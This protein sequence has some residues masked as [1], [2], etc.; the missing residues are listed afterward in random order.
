MIV[1]KPGFPRTAAIM[2][3]GAAVALL[4]AVQATDAQAKDVGIASAVTNVVRLKNPGEPQPHAAKVRETIALA[5]QVSTAA[6]S[7]LQILLLDKSTFSVGANARLTIDRFVYDP[8]QKNNFTATVA[9]GAFRF[10][11]GSKGHGAS[12][13][14]KTPVASI[15]VRGT[16]V[17]GIVGADAITLTT[18]ERGVGRIANA[19]PETATLVVLRGPGAGTLGNVTPGAISVE[20]GGKTV[21]T[22]RPSM[23]VFVPYPGAQPIGPFALSTSGLRQIED[24]ILPAADPILISGELPTYKRPENRRLPGGIV[25]TVPIGD[26]GADDQP[27]RNPTFPGPSIFNNLPQPRGGNPPAPVNRPGAAVAQDAGPPAAQARPPA[28]DPAPAQPPK[29]QADAPPAQSPKDQAVAPPA[30][31]PVAAV[32]AQSPPPPPLKRPG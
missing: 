10:M 23:A 12:S 2:L 1:A 31:A 14:I 24:M 3:T 20:A 30:Q 17:D 32:P 6:A 15:G 16:I 5:E 11:S 27:A 13:S 4:S 19:D 29:D 22:D 21:E 25:P 28:G 7:R 18:R 8:D 9:K 26:L